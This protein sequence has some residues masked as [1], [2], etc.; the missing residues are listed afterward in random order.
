MCLA[1]DCMTGLTCADTVHDQHADYQ[2]SHEGCE[3]PNDR[4][5]RRVACSTR[6][7]SRGSRQSTS[8]TAEGVL[9]ARQ[10]VAEAPRHCQC[11]HRGNVKLP[12]VGCA[13]VVAFIRI[14]IAALVSGTL[15]LRLDPMIPELRLAHVSAQACAACAR[16]TSLPRCTTSRFDDMRFLRRRSLLTSSDDDVCRPCSIRRGAVS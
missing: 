6:P 13:F 11:A 1:P 15:H 16:A 14:R 12:V 10:E 5:D 8:L 2:D 7:L 3:S 9:Q 4:G